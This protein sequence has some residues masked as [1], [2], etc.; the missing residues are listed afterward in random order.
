MGLQT[1]TQWDWCTW[2]VRI[3]ELPDHV[4]VAIRC[5]AYGLLGDEQEFARWCQPFISKYDID[6]RPLVMDNPH[7]NERVFIFDDFAVVQKP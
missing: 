7:N 3:T 2:T 6:P 4:A 1:R 5:S